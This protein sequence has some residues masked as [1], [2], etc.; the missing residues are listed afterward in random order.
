MSTA[1]AP[2]YWG[3]PLSKVLF[4]ESYRPEWTQTITPVSSLQNENLENEFAERARPQ[5]DTD[6]TVHIEAAL[7]DLQGIEVDVPQSEKVRDY[8]LRYFDLT[9]LIPLVCSM[10]RKKFALEA[11]LS[12]EL[13]RDPEIEDEYLVLY[14]RQENY[15]ERIMDKIEDVCDEYE[16]MLSGKSGWLLV[17]TDFSPPHES[18]ICPLIGKNILN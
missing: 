11:Y 7:N 18:I 4:L 2:G 16:V 9:S 10:A 15:D 8:L 12:L 6:V 14:V 1:E 17:T 3:Q 5:S 13:Y